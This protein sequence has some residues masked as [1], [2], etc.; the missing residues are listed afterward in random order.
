MS[1]T[2][3]I[4]EFTIDGHYIGEEITAGGKPRITVCVK[5]KSTIM[6]VAIIRDG[7]ILYSVNPRSHLSKFEYVDDAFEGNSYY[8]LRV[9]QVDNDELG[10]PS[11]AWSNPIWI[12]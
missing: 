8:Y 10:N 7:F 12:K 3:I 11:R 2:R 4:L 6:E 1:N 5:A 9:T